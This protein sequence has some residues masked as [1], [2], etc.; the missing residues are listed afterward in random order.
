MQTRIEEAG[1]GTTCPAQRAAVRGAVVALTAQVRPSGYTRWSYL[2]Q[3]RRAARAEQERLAAART[4]GPHC[5]VGSPPSPDYRLVAQEA[6]RPASS[7]A[8]RAVSSSGRAVCPECGMLVLEQ[9][10]VHPDP[11]LPCKALWETR[12]PSIL[13]AD[14]AGYVAMKAHGYHGLVRAHQRPEST[15]ASA[16]A[17][18]DIFP[19]QVMDAAERGRRSAGHG[20][21]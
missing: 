21:A 9:Y 12:H 20:A 13:F 4:S 8:G 10:V 11:H 16:S 1:L 15:V 7:A 17:I 2:D 6:R 14:N 19:L 5:R 18:G 3:A